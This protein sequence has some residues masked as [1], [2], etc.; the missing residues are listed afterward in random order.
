MVFIFSNDRFVMQY[1]RDLVLSMKKGK[2]ALF[3]IGIFESDVNGLEFDLEIKLSESGKQLKE[4][5]LTVC[6]ILPAQI[7][8]LY[9]SL[10]LGL[11]PDSPSESGAISRVVED[12]T[13][14]KY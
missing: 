1:E 4:E 12:V 3:T 14:Y 2:K 6:D 13:I 11:K 10:A 5:F 7:L 8:G 9:K